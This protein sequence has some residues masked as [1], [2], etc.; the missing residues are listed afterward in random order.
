MTGPPAPHAVP[1]V[2]GLRERLVAL[3]FT[4]EGI[5]ER[6]GSA[7]DVLAREAELPVRLRRVGDTD[8]LALLLRALVLG[9]PLDDARAR[10]LLP[11]EVYGALTASGVLE[12]R[13]GERSRGRSTAARAPACGRGCSRGTPGTSSPPTSASARSPTPRS[14]SR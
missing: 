11:A 1:A 6:L 8:A 14:T 12:L 10:A 3:G 5:R 4:R 2:E 13:G 7:G 9:A